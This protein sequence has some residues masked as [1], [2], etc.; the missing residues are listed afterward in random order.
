VAGSVSLQISRDDPFDGA[1]V[2]LVEG[3]RGQNV[4]SYDIT[5]PDRSSPC[6]GS[7]RVLLPTGFLG[8]IVRVTPH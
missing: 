2:P 7:S 4:Y 3:D 1:L 5:K 6:I 8:L